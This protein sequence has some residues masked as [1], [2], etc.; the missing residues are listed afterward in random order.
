[1]IEFNPFFIVLAVLALAATLAA[2]VVRRRRTFSG[3]EEV[4]DEVQRAAKM[5]K[6][7]ISREG[8]DL[9]VQGGYVGKPVTLRFS[10]DDNAPGLSIRMGVPSN[11]DMS[12]FARSGSAAK[13][14]KVRVYA[15]DRAFDS[16]FAMWSNQPFDAKLFLSQRGTIASIKRICHSPHSFLNIA[17]GIAETGEPIISAA[18]LADRVLTQLGHLGELSEMFLAM[19]GA[20]NIKVLRRSKPRRTLA[21]VAVVAGLTVALGLTLG[22]RG[23]TSP[24]SQPVQA[25]QLSGVAPADASLIANLDLWRSA[26]EA[27]YDPDAVAWLRSEGIAPGG[28]ITGDFSGKNNGRDNDV[29]Y[30]LKN[31]G[32]GLMRI[33]VLSHGKN[34]Y[35]LR[36]RSITGAVRVPRSQ[37][38]SIAWQTPLPGLADGDGLLIATK[39]G[40]RA[41][42]LVLA[43]HGQELML[44]VP[45][46]YQKVSLF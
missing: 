21:R 2:I 37:L 45:A 43:F 18:G 1:M 11:F 25:S 34:I 12:V 35:D 8:A 7:E 38:N 40:D 16:G 29:A 39:T 15:N 20:D 36:Y 19:P 27:D 23:L 5:L 22:L 9:V 33:V 13:R 31:Q 6:A 10:R 41:S 30:I 26:T 28:R 14:G 4:R 32:D 42:G 24:A 46:D 17:P 3:Y 44:G